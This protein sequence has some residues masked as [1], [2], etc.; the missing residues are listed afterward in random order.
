MIGDQQV[1]FANFCSKLGCSQTTIR[2][3]IKGQPD[4]RKSKFNGTHVG[5][6][7]RECHAAV[8]CDHFFRELHQSVA[9]AMP[10]DDEAVMDDPWDQDS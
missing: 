2:K 8:K 7:S 1:C 4:M 10:E 3:Y 6:Q 5:G 9:E